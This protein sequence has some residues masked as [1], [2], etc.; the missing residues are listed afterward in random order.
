MS[1]LRLKKI[2]KIGKV[3]LRLS[4]KFRLYHFKN[5]QTFNK[6]RSNQLHIGWL[7]IEKIL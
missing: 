5:A 7:F 6:Q 2:F 3:V 1:N 4:N